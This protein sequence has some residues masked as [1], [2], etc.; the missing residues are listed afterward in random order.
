MVDE[1]GTKRVLEIRS[2]TVVQANRPM[3]GS[4][5]SPHSKSWLEGSW[6]NV[7]TSSLIGAA[8]RKLLVGVYL[9]SSN[10]W[11]WLGDFIELQDGLVCAV[12]LMAAVGCGIP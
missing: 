9:T 10:L 2:K 12:T 5:A 7:A 8:N 4:D 1:A 6:S 11:V 3:R